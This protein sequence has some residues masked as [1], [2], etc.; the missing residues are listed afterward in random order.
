MFKAMETAFITL[1]DFKVCAIIVKNVYSGIEENLSVMI[2][3]RN[4][5]IVWLLFI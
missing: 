3:S 4:L 2:V 5:I 1:G